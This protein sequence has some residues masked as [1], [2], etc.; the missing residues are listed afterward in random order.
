[1]RVKLGPL[2]GPGTVSTKSRGR[3]IATGSPPGISRAG[4]QESRFTNKEFA[5][6]FDLREHKF[7]I[8][9]WV[10]EQPELPD[11][12]EAQRLFPQV[13]IKVIRAAIQSRRDRESQS[14]R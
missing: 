1:M 8:E 6:V 2:L 14:K 12:K 3:R 5:A 9:K 13:P 11:R 7:M 10:A 4:K